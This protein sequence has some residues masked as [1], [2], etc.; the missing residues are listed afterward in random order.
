M[1]YLTVTF[2]AATSLLGIKRSAPAQTRELHER[3]IND[4]ME[5]SREILR[6]MSLDSNVS[7]ASHALQSLDTL[8]DEIAQ[9]MTTRCQS[10]ATT[11]QVTSAEQDVNDSLE[12]IVDLDGF[13][14]LANPSAMLSMQTPGLDM[15]WLAGSDP[16]LS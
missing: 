4:N 11:M 5:K 14:W 10:S 6:Y 3:I 1:I 12:S 13:D 15:S 16:W 9:E 2:T 7:V 8:E